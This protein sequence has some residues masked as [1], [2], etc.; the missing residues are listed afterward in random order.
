VPEEHGVDSICATG[1]PE[2]R[3]SRACVSEP[4]HLF[5]ASLSVRIALSVAGFQNFG[6]QAAKTMGVFLMKQVH[7]RLVRPE[8]RNLLPFGALLSIIRTLIAIIRTRIATASTLF[9]AL[10]VCSL[11]FSRA[12]ATRRC[13]ISTISIRSLSSGT[14]RCR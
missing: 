12:R 8:S 13:A 10:A 3:P 5:G 1:R 6:Q 9:G 7:A 11:G 14:W 4:T 2:P